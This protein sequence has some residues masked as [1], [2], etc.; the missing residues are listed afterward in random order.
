VLFFQQMTGNWTPASFCPA[1]LS[2]TLGVGL[3]ILG[4]VQWNGKMVSLGFSGVMLGLYLFC[5]WPTERRSVEQDPFVS[6]LGDDM[7]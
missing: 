4:L 5:L 6:E 3:M 1:V 7:P 2:V